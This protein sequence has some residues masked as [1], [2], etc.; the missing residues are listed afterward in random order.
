MRIS[1]YQKK[2][3]SALKLRPH[4]ESENV[5]A[6]VVLTGEENTP[7]IDVGLGDQVYSVGVEEAKKL[8]T[9]IKLVAR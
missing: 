9:W 6:T 8:A 1:T 5:N 3:E 7:V 2:M 4:F